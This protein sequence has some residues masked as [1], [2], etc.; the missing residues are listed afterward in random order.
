M[1]LTRRDQANH[2]R[3]CLQSIAAIAVLA[4]TAAT[5]ASVDQPAAALTQEEVTSGNCSSG[6]LKYQFTGTWTGGTPPHN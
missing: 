5:M 6:G 3:R 2:F 1:M 4:A